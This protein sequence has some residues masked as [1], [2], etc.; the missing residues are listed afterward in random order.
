MSTIVSEIEQAR[1]QLEGGLDGLLELR[2]LPSVAMKVM[3][4]CRDE[5]M[6][7]RGLVQLMECDAAISTRILS[8]VNSSL[9][10]YSREVASLNQAVVVLGRKSL[11]SMAV[12]IA[13]EGVFASGEDGQDSRTRLFEHSL[14][15]AAISRLLASQECFQAES[16]E[17]FLAGLLHDVGKLL[18][19][20]VAPNYYSS[21]S[22]NPA[23][24]DSIATEQEMFGVDHA[25]LGAKFGENW[26]LPAQINHAIA[27]HHRSSCET[28]SA[29]LTVT[30]LAN[31]LAKSWGIGQ[32]EIPQDDNPGEWFE[33]LDAEEVETL[34]ARAVQDFKEIKSL[35]GS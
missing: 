13:S 20:D 23:E 7:A 30:S 2:P 17:A 35:L 21:S 32:E 11:A 22:S 5:K 18:L 4:A 3:E 12:A 29:L 19:I 24:V 15:C 25:A 14:A 9:F 28:N 10:G 27:H 26:G 8:M 6:D 33:T 34:K 1:A 31:R 16:G